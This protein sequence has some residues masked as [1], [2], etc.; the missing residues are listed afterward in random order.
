MKFKDHQDH[1]ELL[2]QMRKKEENPNVRF[3]ENNPW[4]LLACVVLR[5]K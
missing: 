1:D 3:D 4:A 5:G 2:H